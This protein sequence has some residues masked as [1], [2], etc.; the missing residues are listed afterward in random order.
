MNPNQH[1]KNIV[2]SAIGVGGLALCTLIAGSFAETKADPVSLGTA[3]QFAVLYI[4]SNTGN[5][6]Q[7]S[8]PQGSVTGNV[9]L[10]HGN[11]DTSGPV[12][13]GNVYFAGT[14]SVSQPARVNGMII[15]NSPLV[16]QANLDARNA[17]SMAAALAATNST[18][19]IHSSTT[20]TGGA[21]VNVVNLTDVVLNG[22]NLTLIAPAGGS[23][24]L[25][26][27]GGFILNGSSVLLG[28][29][30]TSNDVLIDVIGAGSDVHTTGGGNR[31]VINGTVLAVDRSI[32]LSPGLVNGRIIAGG[33]VITIVSGAKVN[34]PPPEVPEP[35]TVLLLGT[36]LA[37]IAGA[38]RKRRNAWKR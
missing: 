18:T 15:Q 22:G 37:G 25:N 32:K 38:I 8:N 31:S 21:G 33:D 27:T 13:N 5:T 7:M 9:G 16:T 24:V 20:L 11:L 35:G 29:G 30:L 6:V 3:S 17:S 12:I 4:G 1:F 36:G 26:V 10:L 2:K 28:G 34:G 23:W 19:S 14:G